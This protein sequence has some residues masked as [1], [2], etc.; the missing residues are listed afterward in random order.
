MK[1]AL[2][3]LARTPGFI[4]V[5]ILTLGLG[6]GACTTVFSWTERVLLN[7]LPGVVDAGRVVSIE[8]RGPSGA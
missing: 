6:I 7:P 3:R 5:A 2:R 8:T 4:A 1:F